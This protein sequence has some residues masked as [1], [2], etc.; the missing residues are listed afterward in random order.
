MCKDKEKLKKERAEAKKLRTKIVGVGNTMDSYGD[1]FLSAPND[2]EGKRDFQSKESYTKPSGY[3]GQNDKN[4]GDNV[5]SIGSYDPYKSS[6]PL[7]EKI[8]VILDDVEKINEGDKADVIKAKLAQG[9]NK[10]YLYKTKNQ[11]GG[12]FRYR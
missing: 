10:K 1:K 11:R 2:T 12:L 3:S 7:R 9:G 6:K 5:N 4:N 8:G